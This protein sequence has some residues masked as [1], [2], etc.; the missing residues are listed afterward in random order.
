MY[1]FVCQ[2][3]SLLLASV[4][5]TASKFLFYSLKKQSLPLI[6]NK[7]QLTPLS[8]C[9][10]NSYLQIVACHLKPCVL[11]LE[12]T[13]PTFKRFLHFLFLD[14]HFSGFGSTLISGSF[15][16]IEWPQAIGEAFQ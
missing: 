16:L 14:S 12:E 5:P 1:V 3:S 15:I 2:R 13:N 10:F 6:T 4:Q 8:S 11:F 9:P 7:Q